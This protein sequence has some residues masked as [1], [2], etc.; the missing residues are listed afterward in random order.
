MSG[1]R[2]GFCKCPLLTSGRLH[3]RKPKSGKTCRLSGSC[4]R[5]RRIHSHGKAPSSR[6][7]NSLHAI[8]PGSPIQTVG[9]SREDRSRYKKTAGNKSSAPA[10]QSISAAQVVGVPNNSEQTAHFEWHFVS[11][12]TGGDFAETPIKACFRPFLTMPLPFATSRLICGFWPKNARFQNS[13]QI[14]E[15]TALT[16][17]AC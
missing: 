11:P 10:W 2:F 13:E 5:V 9:R 17:F 6:S 3:E 7:Q 8:W 1:A 4:G 16:G 15:Q 14:S 12:R